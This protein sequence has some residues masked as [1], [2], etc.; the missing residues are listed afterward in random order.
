M[1]PNW[2]N[3]Q[4]GLCPK[5]ALALRPLPA[6]RPMLWKCDTEK[7]CKYVIR[8]VRR[9]EIVLN[10]SLPPVTDNSSSLNNL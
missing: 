4:K 7:G 3:L 5:C 9:A 6:F 2:N 1:K 8:E 10:L